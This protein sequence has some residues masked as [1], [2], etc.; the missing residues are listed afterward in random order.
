MPLRRSVLVW[1]ARSLS[2][3]PLVGLVSGL[4]VAAAVVLTSPVAEAKTAIESRYGFE[5]TWNAA[6]RLVRVDMGF[7]VVE[8]DDAA[9]YVLFEY[10]SPESGNKPSQGSIELVRVA[11]KAKPAADEG[12]TNENL[13]QVIVQLPAMPRYHEM[14]LADSLT[15]KMRTEY[16]EPPPPT[17]KPSPPAKDAGVDDPQP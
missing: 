15:R 3:A 10:K 2:S 5:R 6:L 1:V 13:V 8:K 14:A 17:R 16:G 9:G 4:G 12:S 11:P 7:K